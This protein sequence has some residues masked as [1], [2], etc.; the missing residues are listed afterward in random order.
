M[1][2]KGDPRVLRFVSNPQITSW[3]NVG[4]ANYGASVS[5]DNNTSYARGPGKDQPNFGHHLRLSANDPSLAGNE[6]V[7]AVRARIK[8]NV[9]DSGGSTRRSGLYFQV[10]R[11]FNYHGLD[12]SYISY[13]PTFVSTPTEY[14]GRWFDK[15]PDGRNWWDLRSDGVIAINEAM[16]FLID[17]TPQSFTSGQQIRVY[18]VYLDYIV[19]RQPSLSNLALSGLTSTTRP[20]V[21]YDWSD[22]D[23]DVQR[24][25]K[26][27]VFTNAQTQLA[28]F[29]PET[30]K[31][32]YSSTLV[33][34]L[35]EHTFQ[36]DLQDGVQYRVYVKAAHELGTKGYWYSDWQS[37]TFTITLT[38]PA[39]PTLTLG[40]YDTAEDRALLSLAGKINMLTADDASFETTV[41]SWV[42][43]TNAGIA[44]ST[45]APFHGVAAGR[46]TVSGAGAFRVKSGPYAA[47]AGRTYGV[48]GRSRANATSRTFTVEIRYY[49][50][51]AGTTQ[52]GAFTSAGVAETVGA[53]SAFQTASGAAPAGTVRM[54]AFASYNNG[55]AA[56]IHDI[57]AYIIVPGGAPAAFHAGGL[58]AATSYQVQY[59]DLPRRGNLVPDNIAS[60][61]E[62]DL[63]VDGFFPRQ[64]ADTIE[65]TQEVQP[66]RGRRCLRW[67]VSNSGSVLDIG[68]RQNELDFWLWGAVVGKTYEGSLRMRL[69]PGSTSQN[70]S[71]TFRF[72]DGTGATVGSMASGNVSISG[73]AWTNVE[74]PDTAAP[75]GTVAVRLEL[76][77]QSGVTN[78][79]VFV[80]NIQ[81]GEFPYLL[82]QNGPGQG[83][84][85]DWRA[86]RESVDADDGAVDAITLYSD[87]VAEQ[88]AAFYDYEVPPD[89]LRIYRARAISLQG[90]VDTAS[91]WTAWQAQSLDLAT[92]WL[93]HPFQPKLNWKPTLRG[94]RPY[95]PK[96]GLRRGF[97]PI[98]GRRTPVV[99]VS[100]NTSDLWTMTLFAQNDR[101]W[102]RLDEMVEGS[103]PLLLKTPERQWY[104]QPADD[105]DLKHWL[106][107][108]GE[109]EM[110]VLEFTVVEVATP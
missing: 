5:D 10:R 36:S 31:A 3:T 52:I 11:S 97:H 82:T 83:E 75:A 93:K 38:G 89:K 37:T 47:I 16:V 62:T 20:T 106:S 51:T 63:S 67:F 85:I 18:E 26:V 96:R 98:I 69:Y 104:F 92:T 109:A 88:E 42:N 55:A 17:N 43:D 95:H 110:R 56:E 12:A 1:P 64:A 60:G 19:N 87:T 58:L 21:T 108:V 79:P 66:Y 23:G 24:I 40:T 81:F 6:R 4:G 61:G 65:V 105:L 50:D 39:A 59:A 73:S 15:D 34:S 86:W 71:A 32:I 99:L 49:S 48:G 13:V 27:K 78:F 22:A 45:A 101:D 84:A 91:P 74:C 41:G 44:R 25:Q 70:F 30:A 107:N 80:D 35:T 28:G 14:F 102:E 29:D 94:M 54:R 103:G 77:N 9:N 53:Y 7:V 68:S 33:T 46:I 76:Q 57:D 72:I 8:A 2:A 90:G 100:K